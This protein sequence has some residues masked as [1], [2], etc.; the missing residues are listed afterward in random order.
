MQHGR[1]ARPEQRAQRRPDRQ[2]ADSRHRA[3]EL[4]VAPAE[5]DPLIGGKALRDGD[6][7][8]I[9]A[10]ARELRE[11]RARQRD[12]RMIAVADDGDLDRARAGTRRPEHRI[13]GTRRDHSR[14]RESDER[15]QTAP[16]G[17][18]RGGLSSGACHAAPFSRSSASTIL[19]RRSSASSRFSRSP[20]TTSSGA[21]FMKSGLPSLASTRLMSASALAIFLGEPRL[22]G[23][24]V[25]DALE[26][27]RRDLAAHDELHRR[28]AAAASRDRTPRTR[29]RARL[30]K[31]APSDRRAPR[32]SFRR[33]DQH[34]RRRP[35][36]MFISATHR[37]DRA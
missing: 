20:S 18:C 4:L 33:V 35:A 30:R 32:V 34:E 13:A 7:R 16:A 9:A 6:Q 2:V 23:R 8:R 1:I 26:R 14:R 28:P 27:Q 37:A 5:L 10:A 12:A 3:V 19:P 15:D 36:V 22:L 17:Q 21:R 11:R 29:A 25:D 24:D 31:I